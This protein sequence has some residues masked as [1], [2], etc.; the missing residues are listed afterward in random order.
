MG[1][2]GNTGPEYLLTM[3]TVRLGKCGQRISILAPTIGTMGGHH[4]LK[5]DT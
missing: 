5:F 4:H 2:Q 3:W 1:P